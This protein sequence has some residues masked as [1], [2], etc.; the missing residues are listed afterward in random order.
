MS[1]GLFVPKGASL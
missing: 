1:G